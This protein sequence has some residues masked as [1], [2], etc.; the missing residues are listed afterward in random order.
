MQF[1]ELDFRKINE[2]AHAFRAEA[3][4]DN[5][6]G[7]SVVKSPMSY[8]GDAGLYELAVL[9]ATG[10]L[11]YT[12]PITADVIG[13]AAMRVGR[14]AKMYAVAPATARTTASLV[15]PTARDPP[16]HGESRRIDTN[17]SPSNLTS[18]EKL[19]SLPCD[20]SKSWKVPSTVP[21][22]RRACSTATPARGPIN[23]HGPARST[24]PAPRR[25]R[26]GPSWRH[27]VAQIAGR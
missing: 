3:R 24:R 15:P 6:R 19:E 18:Q 21:P 1:S 16:E 14:R 22:M 9:D 10:K 27:G 26:R 13:R 11:D 7:A 25:S 17:Y 4:F 23:P 20:P 12:T 5:G 8:G 2:R